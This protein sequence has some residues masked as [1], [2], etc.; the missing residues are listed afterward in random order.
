LVGATIAIVFV[1]VPVSVPILLFVIVGAKVNSLPAP[2]ALSKLA[3]SEFSDFVS[4]FSK[5]MVLEVAVELVIIEL[6]LGGPLLVVFTVLS[7]CF[8]I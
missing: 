2:N 5:V 4:S 6:P 8:F 3:Q 1:P 7:S